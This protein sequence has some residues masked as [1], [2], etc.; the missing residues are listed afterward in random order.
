MLLYI[1]LVATGVGGG[2]LGHTVLMGRQLHRARHDPVT[3]LAVRAAWARRAGRTLARGMSSVVL[4]D[5]DDFKI[6]ND[7]YG[8]AA[9]DQ[10]L[11]AQARRIGAWLARAGGGACGRLGGDEFAIVTRGPIADGVIAALAAALADPVPLPHVGAVAVSASVGAVACGRG[12]SLSRALAGADA[13]L[14]A[15]KRA[16]GGSWRAGGAPVLPE[17]RPARRYRHH[18]PAAAVGVPT[19]SA[20]GPG[21]VLTGAPGGP[22]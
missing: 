21:D 5:L 2:W 20:A 7:A 6:I 15:A 13:A 22:E 19:D 17:G 4:V 3:G 12:E 10:V 11:A 8:H 9:G 18:G 14:Y 1:E 16:G